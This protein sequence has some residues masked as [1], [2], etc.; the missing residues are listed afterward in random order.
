MTGP[1]GSPW[2]CKQ[3]PDLFRQCTPAGWRPVLRAQRPAAV[4]HG[5]RRVGD[6]RPDQ[7][8]A[9]ACR[10]W[11]PIPSLV[12]VMKMLG[13]VLQGIQNGDAKLKDIEPQLT[14]LAGTFEKAV[15]EKPAFFSWRTLV[16]GDSP[17]LRDT[18]RVILVQPEMDFSQLQPGQRASDAIRATARSLDLDPAHGVTVRLT[19]QVP[20][21]DEEFGSLSDDAGLI[22]VAMVAALLGI[23]WLAVRSTRITVAILCT[24]LIG[25]V[26]TAAIGLLAVGRFNLISVAFIPLFVGLG[27]RLQHPVQRAQPCRA[28]RPADSS[29]WRSWRPARPSARR[30][31]CRPR[32]SAWASSPSFRPVTWGVAE[33]GTIAGLGMIVAFAL[34]IVL[35]PA[36]LVL[37]RAPQAGMKEIGFTMLAPVDDLVHRHRRSVLFVAGPCRDRGLCAAAAA[38]FRL[39]S[40]QPQEF[41]RSKLMTTLYKDMEHDPRLES[42]RH[43]RSRA[44]AGRRGAAGAPAG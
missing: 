16:T 24:T 14:A 41:R 21:A 10:R 32:P 12:G 27:R 13:V 18:R 35:L 11:P 43:Q 28:A 9:A 40:A 6:G 8:A 31:V 44:V 26:M 19:G 20:L 33:L 37:L 4:V 38:A 3:R 30:G 5:R 29:R 23:L 36:L 7:G 42:R 17:D 15:A 2:R 25:L 34:T 22:T 39:Q 1:G